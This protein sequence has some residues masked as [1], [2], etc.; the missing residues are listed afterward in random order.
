MQLVCRVISCH[1]MLNNFSEFIAHLI[2]N[3][4]GDVWQLVL[5]LREI[6]QMIVAPR[7]QLI[8]LVT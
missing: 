1:K 5:K 2:T 6:V 4:T 8:R 3:H 7:I